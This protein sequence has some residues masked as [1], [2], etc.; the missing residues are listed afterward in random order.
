MIFSE[1]SVWFIF[2]L[3]KSFN[4]NFGS[5]ENTYP[6]PCCFIGYQL[7]L[8][9]YKYL[10]IPKPDE[11]TLLNALDIPPFIDS[12]S[13]IFDPSSF[14]IHLPLI[15]IESVHIKPPV[16]SLYDTF[17]LSTPTTSSNLVCIALACT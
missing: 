15:K 11:A 14:D 6:F 7:F 3:S 8:D 5:T 13:V 2:L 10:P 1:F 4:S 12:N 17:H 16:T 9:L